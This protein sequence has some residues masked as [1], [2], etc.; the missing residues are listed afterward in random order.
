MRFRNWL[1]V[2][3]VFL[4]AIPCS[5]QFFGVA[6]Y[7]GDV[8]GP[9]VA[10]FSTKAAT[11]AWATGTK[12]AFDVVV[13]DGAGVQVGGTTTLNYIDGAFE[14]AKATSLLG[15]VTLG[16]P[17][18]SVLP[19]QYARQIFISKWYDQS[20]SNACSGSPC[21]A[22][23]VAGDTAVINYPV[24]QI[25]GQT[26]HVSFGNSFDVGDSRR[27]K[28]PDAV[29]LST[30]ATT[31][32]TVASQFNTNA[33]SGGSAIFYTSNDGTSGMG[34]VRPSDGS[35]D[36][37]TAR[38]YSWRTV[39]ET[40]LIPTHAD[41]QA[42]SISAGPSTGEI[43]NDLGT[44]SFS[45]L[46]LLTGT[47][48][49][50]G[51]TDT[52]S[53]AASGGCFHGGI[54]LLTIKSSYSTPTVTADMRAVASRFFNLNTSP[55]Q[56]N[57]VI[58]GDSGVYGYANFFPGISGSNQGSENFGTTQMFPANLKKTVR[59]NN[60]A[61]GGSNYQPGTGNSI[62]DRAPR[63]RAMATAQ[64]NATINIA[65]SMPGATP[66]APG[67]ATTAQIGYIEQYAQAL[68][69]TGQT[70]TVFI[71]NQDGSPCATADGIAFDTALRAA[72]AADVGTNKAFTVVKLW[73]LSGVNC[74][75]NLYGIAN[76]ISPPALA[77]G[78]SWAI[79]V[80]VSD[81]IAQVNAVLP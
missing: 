63:A 13:Y 64:P 3:A 25:L 2:L 48:F 45:P 9:Y 70:W 28:L 60:T 65:I 81:G 69:S 50:I 76:V 56:A 43:A 77:H 17:S 33:N 66:P 6:T 54:D 24:L 75:G 39:G 21:N 55:A 16:S 52:G 20:G 7:P 31:V 5:A 40:A 62:V 51:C 34:I 32:L 11:A 10:V 73:G 15:P 68:R 26:I 67:S 44:A 29:A 35:N 19:G 74:L 8:N 49:V 18:A 37:T 27:L 23:P 57:L 46:T 71:G 22:V 53:T 30:Q 1:V 38:S 14:V 36:G 12:P 41:A 58:E 78:Y 47:G 61:R 79:G 72:S 4:W 42:L 59:V 80:N